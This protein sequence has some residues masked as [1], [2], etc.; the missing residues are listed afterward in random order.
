MYLKLERWRIV[1]QS[2]EYKVLCRYF[3]VAKDPTIA[4]SIFDGRA[5]SSWCHTPPRLC[6]PDPHDIVQHFVSLGGRPGIAVWDYRHYFHQIA[7]HA[8]IRQYFCV[9]VDNKIYQWQV[10]PM[11]WSYSPA[12]AQALA[13]GVMIEALRHKKWDMRAMDVLDDTCIPAYVEAFH[14]QTRRAI[15]AYVTYDNVCILGETDDVDSARATIVANC[16]ARSLIIKEG[17]DRFLGWKK[18]LAGERVDHLGLS[19]GATR[20]TRSVQL[21]EKTRTR[22]RSVLEELKPRLPKGCFTCRDLARVIGA[23]LHAHRAIHG[24]FLGA[25]EVL[26]VARELGKQVVNWSASCVID[27]RRVRDLL[28]EFE[29]LINASPVHFPSRNP[30]APPAKIVIVA[31]DACDYGGGFVRVSEEGVLV[32]EVSFPLAKD[33][34][35]FNKEVIAARE[36]VI[37]WTSRY[38]GARIILLEDNVAAAFAIAR[39]WSTSEAATE[40][41]KRLHEALRKHRCT[42]TVMSVP[43]ESNP[44]D[45]TSRFKPLDQ[46]KGNLFVHLFHSQA[47]EANLP[48]R[49]S[50]Y[51]ADLR[52]W[53]AQECQKTELF[54]TASQWPDTVER[55]PENPAE[56]VW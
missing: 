49:R 19:I 31:A 14:P 5:V 26:R 54:E 40:D 47:V 34:H 33:L 16:R 24:H 35:I 45:E 12:V 22:W 21:S 1:Q 15:R 53:E 27:E 56:E 55:R 52:H 11:G 36:A 25:H 7:L 37:Y 6:L 39:G 44:A 48:A 13:L 42:L 10:L 51:V 3:A 41:I 50:P 8:D 18:L 32:E 23:I 43:G 46:A 17:S 4:R 28:D 29:R 2:K 30:N 9:S 20:C 38:P